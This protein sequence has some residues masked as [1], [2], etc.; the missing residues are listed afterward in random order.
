M[1]SHS[2][3]LTAGEKGAWFRQEDSWLNYLPNQRLQ[4]VQTEI[5]VWFG[6]LQD[7]H[8]KSKHIPA[9]MFLLV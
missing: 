1:I 5:S 9:D 8:V 3:T 6:Y 2:G 4:S 7:I